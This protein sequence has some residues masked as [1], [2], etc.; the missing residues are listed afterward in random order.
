M[1]AKAAAARASYP[2]SFFI[3]EIGPSPVDYIAPQPHHLKGSKMK[4][5][6][7]R[8]AV[9]VLLG[10][11]LVALSQKSVAEVLQPY[12]DNHTLAGAVGLVANK[13]K[14]LDVE[15][16]GYADV[17]GSRPMLID[18]IFWIASM[19]KPITAAAVMMLVDEG[20][21]KLDDPV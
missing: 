10:A 16:V 15:A 8:I 6:L 20:K 21:L 14:V 12:V 4:N 5:L 3:C 13:D 19:S 18:A 9:A 17:S 2:A 7:S 1:P 11:V